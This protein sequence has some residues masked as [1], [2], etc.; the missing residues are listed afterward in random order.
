MICF[1]KYLPCNCFQ[2]Y[3]AITLLLLL[4]FLLLLF[5]VVQ[6]LDSFN[7]TRFFRAMTT[8]GDKPFILVKQSKP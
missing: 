7:Q 3:N 2:H 8:I 5:Y 4:L 6:S 1:P